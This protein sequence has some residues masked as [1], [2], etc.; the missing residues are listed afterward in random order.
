MKTKS[1]PEESTLTMRGLPGT[2]GGGIQAVCIRS[3]A[4]ASKMLRMGKAVTTAGDGMAL[5]IWKGDDGLWYCESMR[6]RKTLDMKEFVHLAAAIQWLKTW[7]PRVKS[8]VE[9]GH[10][11]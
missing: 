4:H 5:A 11:A 3:V 9:G 2:N 6:S 7:L 1:K 8:E 10:L